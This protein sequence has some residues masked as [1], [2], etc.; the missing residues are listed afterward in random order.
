VGAREDLLILHG[1]LER[2]REQHGLI[3]K[4]AARVKELKTV[5]DHGRCDFFSPEEVIQ[6]ADAASS[7]QDRRSTSP[8]RSPAWAAA[9]SCSR[10]AGARPPSTRR[11]S[12]GQGELSRPKSG[13]ACTVPMVEQVDHALMKLAGR[14]RHTQPA[15][16]VF[17]GSEGGYMD[18]LAP[19]RGYVAALKRADLRV[20]RLQTCAHLRL[21][22]DQ[23]RLDRHGPGVDGPRRRQH[24]RCAT[25]TTRAAPTTRGCSPTP[26]ALTAMPQT[27]ALARQRERALDV[28]AVGLDRDLLLAKVH[29]RA[30][31][32]RGGVGRRYFFAASK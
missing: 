22:G 4:P 27:G 28:V 8:S 32:P 29:A 3:D 26:S 10:C 15:D 9:A 17:P 30:D 1:V 16:L 23:L 25:W 20:L 2:A 5:Y 18:S 21:A 19:R 24:A 14:E 7:E 6:L 12:C 13:R 11:R 31:G